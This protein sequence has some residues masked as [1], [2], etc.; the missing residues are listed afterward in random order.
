MDFKEAIRSVLKQL[1][2]EKMLIVII[3]TTHI[4][5]LIHTKNSFGLIKSKLRKGFKIW[6]RMFPSFFSSSKNIMLETESLFS[7]F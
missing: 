4:F 1:I 3:L 2:Q 7:G 5:N 6:E